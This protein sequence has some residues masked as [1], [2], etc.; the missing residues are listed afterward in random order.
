MSRVFPVVTGLARSSILL[1]LFHH[2]LPC[3]PYF[4][5]S[6]RSSH[7]AQGAPNSGP[8]FLSVLESSS[9]MSHTLTSCRVLFRCHPSKRLSL[10]TLMSDSTP[11]CP[12]GYSHPSLPFFVVF[13]STCQLCIYCLIYIFYCPSLKPSSAKNFLLFTTTSLVL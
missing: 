10:P 5:C 7:L 12:P 3:S 1:P 11:S 13:I 8:L 2:F 9:T 6:S 4:P